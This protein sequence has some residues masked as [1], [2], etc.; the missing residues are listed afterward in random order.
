MDTWKT[1]FLTSW[2]PMPRMSRLSS[3]L[4]IR[5]TVVGG[6]SEPSLSMGGSNSEAPW[7]HLFTTL[8]CN[9][10]ASFSISN[11]LRAKADNLVRDDLQ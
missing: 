2:S 10:T 4:S 3:I 6:F 7:M 5:G 8:R 9:T 11:S 1:V